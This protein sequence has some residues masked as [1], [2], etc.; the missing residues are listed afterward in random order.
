[1]P[2]DREDWLLA[3]A[4][5]PLCGESMIVRLPKRTERDPLCPPCACAQLASAET[6]IGMIA[7]GLRTELGE[8]AERLPADRREV[9]EA[10]VEQLDRLGRVLGDLGSVE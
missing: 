3:G 9:L 5:C 6:V 1:M 7:C 4:L 8:P 2:T 10:A